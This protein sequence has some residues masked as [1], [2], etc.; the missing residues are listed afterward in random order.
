MSWDLVLGTAAFANF[1]SFAPGSLMPPEYNSGSSNV[2]DRVPPTR[3]QTSDLDSMNT[4]NPENGMLDSKTWLTVEARFSV[5]IS[6]SNLCILHHSSHFRR[7][8]D[9]KFL[10]SW[11]GI[12]GKRQNDFFC[13]RV[14]PLL[15]NGP[16]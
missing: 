8:R 1:V 14:W 7:L 16:P 10:T 11:I 4:R 6:N 3:R 13:K 2:R 9:K 12:S 15:G 5:Q